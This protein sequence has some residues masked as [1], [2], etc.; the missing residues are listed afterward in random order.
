MTIE[1]IKNHDNQNNCMEYMMTVNG[2]V[3][4]CTGDMNDICGNEL[5]QF[6]YHN[7]R[8]LHMELIFQ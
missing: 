8:V 4:K 1:E 2:K 7:K 3:I 6:L 5:N